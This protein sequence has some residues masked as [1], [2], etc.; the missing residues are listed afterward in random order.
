MAKNRGLGTGLGSLLSVNIHDEN[1]ITHKDEIVAGFSELSLDL[2]KPNPS[3]PRKFFDETAIES[4]SK[5]IKTYGMIAP[6][7]VTKIGD[8]YE[9]IAGERRYR[10]SILA[11]LAKVPVVIKNLS[12][13]EKLEVSLVE[14]IQREN[15]NSIEEALAYQSLIESYNLTQEELSERI[16]KSRSAITNSIRLLMLDIPVQ[17]MIIDAQISAGH[18]R[19]VLSLTN[20][21]DQLSFCNHIIKNDLSVRD[22][23]KIAKTFGV[24]D[25]NKITQKPQTEVLELKN[26]RKR[27]EEKFQTKV[28][29][30]GNEIKGRIQIEYFSTEDLERILEVI[31]G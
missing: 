21:K 14:N 5:S 13:K 31:E 23:E 28:N 1:E 30:V 7:A 4:L 29:I 25:T 20:K 11:G 18:A 24:A 16:G 17:K 19:A 9:I 3:Q 27:I 26:A 22:A 12:H 15:L 2:I 6:I 10:A 8:H